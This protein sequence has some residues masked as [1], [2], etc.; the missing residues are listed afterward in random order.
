MMHEE[1]EETNVNTAQQF[2]HTA[3]DGETSDDGLSLSR[4]KPP[5][6]AGGGSFVLSSN[7]LAR[8]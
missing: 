4:I 2:L 7:F 1:R 6:P 3:E 5:A 8:S